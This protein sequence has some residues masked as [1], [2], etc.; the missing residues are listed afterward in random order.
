[1]SVLELLGPE[2]AAE[3]SPAFQ[4]WV[5]GAIVSYPEPREGRQ[6]LRLY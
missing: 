2:G 3:N 4:R 6:T 1:M 5:A